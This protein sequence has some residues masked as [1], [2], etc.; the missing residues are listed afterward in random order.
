[1]TA[2]AADGSSHAAP[3]VRLRRDPGDH[4][5]AHPGQTRLWAVPSVRRACRTDELTLQLCGGPQAGQ[6]G[7]R[8]CGPAEGRRRAYPAVLQI[9]CYVLGTC[10]ERLA[11]GVTPRPHN[12]PETH[13]PDDLHR[14]RQ[15]P[16]E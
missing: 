3:P 15:G 13:F 12:A 4:P 16:T 11:T 10:G 2:A 5:G 7:R 9:R 8:K 14:F 1:M 6:F